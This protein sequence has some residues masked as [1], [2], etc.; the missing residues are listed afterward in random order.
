MKQ[1]GLVLYLCINALHAQTDTVVYRITGMQDVLTSKYVYK[2]AGDTSLTLE[3]YY[4]PKHNKNIKTPAVIFNN[5]VGSLTLPDWP[6]Y[7]DWGKLTAASG[8]IAI[9]YQS[10]Q[11]RSRDDT[12]DVIAYIRTHADEMH[13]DT[14]R[15]GL[16]M[17]SGNVP[18]ALPLAMESARAYIRCAVVYYGSAEVPSI[19]KDL[20]VFYVRSGL[21]QLGLNR[22]IE[23]YVRRA[24][25][26]EAPLTFIHYAEGQHAFDVADDNEQSRRII[27]QTL[28]FLTDHLTQPAKYQDVLT[29]FQFLQLL[30]SDTIQAIAR[31]RQFRS[32]AQ[33]AGKDAR[34]TWAF[35]ER[36]LTGMAYQL[37]QEK[38]NFPSVRLFEEITICYPD[39]PNAFDSLADAYEAVG[40]HSESLRSA[41]KAISLL[42]VSRLPDHFKEQIRQS[43]EQKIKRITK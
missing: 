6:V 37:L 43:A 21:D 14:G 20:P 27:R 18:A 34:W 38:K 9:T 19:R 42:P 2:I 24:L 5:G 28:D 12:E 29:A 16:W 1:I 32:A 25:E 35:N 15:I 23:R 22:A 39:S 3:V 10:R 13:L 33:T 8:L 26:E 36:G 41:Q 31:F 7:R 4:P 30:Q 17:C 40:R 11:G